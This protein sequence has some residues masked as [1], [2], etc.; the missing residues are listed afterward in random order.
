MAAISTLPPFTISVAN[1]H[2]VR[3]FAFRGRPT[4]VRYFKNQQNRIFI[5]VG[6]DSSDG[7]FRKVFIIFGEVRQPPLSPRAP[8]KRFSVKNRRNRRNRRDPTLCMRFRGVG[9][10]NSATGRNAPPGRRVLSRP[11]SGPKLLQSPPDSP[12]P[13]KPRPAHGLPLSRLQKSQSGTTRMAS[14]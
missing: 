5:C 2:Y 6:S 9:S 8:R 4:N 1:D 7:L 11:D 12:A 3:I 13:E 10:G 14:G